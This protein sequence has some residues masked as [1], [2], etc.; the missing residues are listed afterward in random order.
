MLT[1]IGECDGERVLRVQIQAGSAG[2]P[3]I[4]ELEA[5]LHDAERGVAENFVLQF[6]GGPGSAAG[7]FPRWPPGAARPDM[8]Y[9]ARWDEILARMSRLKAKTYAAYDGRV[10]AAGVQA[11][12]VMDL[13]L[14]S[15][16][17]RLRPGGLS[18]GH[19]PGMGAHWLPKFIGLGNARRIF[20]LGE[21]LTAQHA[22]RLGLLDCVEDT[23]EAAIDVTIKAMRPVTA[24]AAC[25]TRRILDESYAMERAAT[26]EL[27][28]AARYKLGMPDAG[29]ERRGEQGCEKE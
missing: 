7:E 4:G 27:T 6:T 18:E 29:A 21:E 2:A 19:F 12:L 22:S 10:G 1:V 15:A 5:A 8:R 13:R 9:F 23:V 24:E 28:K 16:S 26:A 25:Y 17:A 11:G 14:A 3:L 20:L